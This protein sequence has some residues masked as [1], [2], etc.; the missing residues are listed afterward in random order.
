[1]F[2]KQEEELSREFLMTYFPKPS[3]EIRGIIEKK[4]YERDLSIIVCC[5]NQEAYLKK[6]LESVAHYPFKRNVSVIVVDDGSTDGSAEIADSY[7]KLPNFIIAHQENHGIAYTRNQG[8]SLC[9][10]K[11]LFF[12][13]ADDYL[14]PEAVEQMLEYAVSEDADIVE[15]SYRVLRPEEEEP[16]TE[17]FADTVDTFEEI[18]WHRLSGYVWGKVMRTDLFSSLCFPEG[19]LMED[20]IMGFLVAPLCRRVFRYKISSYIYRM[21]PAGITA[22]IQQDSRAVHSYWILETCLRAMPGLGIEMDENLFEKALHWI[23]MNYAIIR[24]Q[25]DNVKTAVFILLCGCM[26]EE[27]CRFSANNRSLRLLQE[28]LRAEDYQLYQQSCEL[29]WKAGM[30]GVK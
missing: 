16:S 5:Y 23:I 19:Y 15:S 20:G 30:Y 22:N 7:G 10:A 25:S 24:F 13:D 4:K 3:G 2:S 1:M 14:I 21:N 17:F 6:C 27:N 12:L 29:A 28:A 18:P 9:D 11:Y 26:R 8:I